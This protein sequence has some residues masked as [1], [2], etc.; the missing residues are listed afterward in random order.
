L[1]ESHGKELDENEIKEV[2]RFAIM[3]EAA[4]MQGPTRMRP[5]A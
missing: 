2:R 4:K 1:T 5:E 3:C